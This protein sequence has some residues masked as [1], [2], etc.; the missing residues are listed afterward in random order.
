M[1]RTHIIDNLP[2]WAV[3]L[4]TIGLG[5]LAVEI[6]FRMGKYGKERNPDEHERHIGAMVA[7][8]LGLWAFLLAFLVGIASDRFNTRRALVVEEANSIGTTYLRAGYLPEPAAGQSRAL[9][10]EYA[11]E[12]VKLTELETYAV[13]RQRAEEIH[14]LLWAM[15]QELASTQPAN[16][17][18]ALYIASLNETIDLHTARITALTVARVPFTIYA[19]MYLVAAL[20]LLMLGFQAGITGRRDLIVTIALIMVFS[21]IMLLIIDLD[22]PWGGL[23]RVSN[24]PFIDLIAGFDS[25]K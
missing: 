10:R 1:V 21:G 13:A 18:L 9:L 20:G 2:L 11:G 5:L 8:T 3:Y 23:L 7:A 14:P 25:F 6:G 12:R 16:P 19:G 22:R 4:L 24:Q 15:A 17:V